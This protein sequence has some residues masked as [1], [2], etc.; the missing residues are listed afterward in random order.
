MLNK[1]KIDLKQFSPH[2]FWDVD[3]NAVD[4]EKNKNWFVERVLE[5]GILSDWQLLKN[6]Y[7][8]QTISEIATNLRCLSKK[9][10]SFISALSDIPK[11]NFRCYT[12]NQSTQN[13]WAY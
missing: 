11:E 12:T 10:V 5:Y 6:L 1:D 7:G 4:I 9:S 8:I 2:L 3:I 13:F